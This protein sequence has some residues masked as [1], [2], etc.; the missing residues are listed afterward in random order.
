MTNEQAIGESLHKM[1]F[2]YSNF[3]AG[4][5]NVAM[6]LRIW[7]YAFPFQHVTDPLAN[8]FLRQVANAVP[9][10]GLG[11]TALLMGE[12]HKLPYLRPRATFLEGGFLDDSGGVPRNVIGICYGCTNPT[13]VVLVNAR[14]GDVG[15]T[16]AVCFTP[17][18]SGETGQKVCPRCGNGTIHI[19]EFD[20]ATLLASTV[21]SV[22][23]MMKITG[24][25]FRGR[26]MERDFPG[27]V[28]DILE[29]PHSNDPELQA[30]ISKK[31]A[32]SLRISYDIDERAAQR[33]IGIV[34][35]KYTGPFV[36]TICDLLPPM[37][38]T[39]RK[40]RPTKSQ[41]K[42]RIFVDLRGDGS[43]EK[44]LRQDDSD[45][46][47][48][49]DSKHP[50][51]LPPRRRLPPLTESSSDS[52][53]SSSSDDSDSGSGSGSDTEVFVDLS[54]DDDSDTKMFADEPSMDDDSDTKMFV[55]EPS[56]DDGSDTKM[57]VDEPATV[58]QPYERPR[59]RLKRAACSKLYARSMPN[60][61]HTSMPNRT[62]TSM[63]NRTHT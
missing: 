42:K 17:R 35:R 56:M 46:S 34:R 40:A 50:A 13:M 3:P 21:L 26:C 54:D 29:L 4:A 31:L 12:A 39:D 28:T 55:D 15:A 57:L 24:M 16:G 19:R 7:E 48:R 51:S 60:R 10:L 62:H 37:E 43:E 8:A 45:D 27:G 23:S 20:I 6:S 59:K 1:L 44:L 52:E 25:D 9:E 5:I 63:P 18:D 36:N 14:K 58:I 22:T 2:V 33:Q 32:T 53:K 49:F 11:K 30:T 47:Q 38:P 61:T 41:S